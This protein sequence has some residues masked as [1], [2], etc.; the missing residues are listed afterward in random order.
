MYSVTVFNDLQHGLYL[1]SVH[2][3]MVVWYCI[4][5]LRKQVAGVE[6]TT[7]N[8]D[9]TIKV[10]TNELELKQKEIVNQNQTIKELREILEH[11]VKQPK[12]VPDAT[13]KHRMG[14][15]SVFAVQCS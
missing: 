4:V 2:I 12:P 1:L 11:Y 7:K 6:Q 14:K 10:L 9:D 13:S 5:R 8:K 15:L 3:L